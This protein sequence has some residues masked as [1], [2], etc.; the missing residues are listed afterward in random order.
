MTKE[1]TEKEEDRVQGMWVC[2]CDIWC[3]LSTFIKILKYPSNPWQEI[4]TYHTIPKQTERFR[5]FGVLKRSTNEY[6]LSLVSACV[7]SSNA[8]EKAEKTNCSFITLL[9]ITVVSVLT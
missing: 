7:E 5:I 9:N 2:M 1:F 3:V 8:C 4:D 6:F